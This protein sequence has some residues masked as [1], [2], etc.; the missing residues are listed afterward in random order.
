MNFVKA[1][2]PYAV[3][4]A[5]NNA[6]KSIRNNPYIRL[7]RNVVSNEK[8]QSAVKMAF[9]EFG[10]Q[11]SGGTIPFPQKKRVSS[12]KRSARGAPASGVGARTRSQ[13]RITDFRGP[14][15]RGAG[16]GAAVVRAPKRYGRTRGA[17]SQRRIYPTRSGG[18]MYR[19]PDYRTRRAQVSGSGTYAAGATRFNRKTYSF[20]KSFYY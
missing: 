11:L 2:A 16:A 3:N 1:V 10:K 19:R 5:Y 15:G 12:P 20:P 9:K 17:R 8:I 13:T 6:P 18:H 4:Y 14:R 7:G